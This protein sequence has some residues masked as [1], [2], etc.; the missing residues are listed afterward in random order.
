M[1]PQFQVFMP[2]FQTFR[3]SSRKCCSIFFSTPIVTFLLILPDLHRFLLQRRHLAGLLLLLHGHRPQLCGD[4][5]RHLQHPRQRPL[6]HHRPPLR[7]GNDSG[8]EL[9]LAN[10]DQR[11]KNLQNFE[12]LKNFEKFSYSTIHFPLRIT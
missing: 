2:C 1:A 8:T 3:Q 5:L 11:R 7:R 9:G 6:R 10:V 12:I 4:H